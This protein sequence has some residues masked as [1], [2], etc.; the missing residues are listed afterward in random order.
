MC[1]VG[2]LGV[3]GEGFLVFIIIVVVSGVVFVVLLEEW[4]EVYS[5]F[6]VGS[7]GVFIIGGVNF[8]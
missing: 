4:Y 5:Y 6:G 3:I 7:V 1:F 2:Y 8:I